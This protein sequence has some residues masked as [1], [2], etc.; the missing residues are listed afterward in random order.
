MMNSMTGFGRAAWRDRRL[1][2]EVEVRSVNHRFLSVKISLPEG[3][4]RYEGEVDRI[5][6]SRL[7]RGTVSVGV[8]LKPLG[9]EAVP[10]PDPERV[11]AFYARLETIR[12]S[13][14]IPGAVS[15]E[16]L[17]SIPPLW[18]AAG[19]EDAL[20]ERAWPMARQLVEK[21]VEDLAA[22]RAREGRAIQKDLLKRLNTIDRSAQRVR[23]RAPHVL[24]AYQRKLDERIGTLLAGRGIPAEKSD[25]L[26]EVA[27]FADRC[28]I[29]EELHRLSNHVAAFRKI[30]RQGGAVGRRLDFLTQEM[31][32]ETNTLASKGGD[33]E[34]S[35]AAVLIKSELEKIKEQAENVE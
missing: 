26:K 25:L 34:I 24:A 6:R 9:E 7:V 33:S 11:K 22:S 13:L 31:V 14:G 5:V 21:A 29:S 3:M 12:R 1:D 28:D 20:A 10:L 23:R 35:Q 19:Q 2:V 16:G 32:R 15:F 30:V 18:T 8:A 27:V 4:T 17:M